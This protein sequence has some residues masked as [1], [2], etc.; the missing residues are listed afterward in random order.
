[1]A[2][3]HFAP[4]VAIEYI[5]SKHK[6]FHTSLARPKPKLVKGD[7]VIVDKRTAF[8]L[9][10]KGFEEFVYVEDIEFKKDSKSA[11]DLKKELIAYKEHNNKLFAQNVALIKELDSLSMTGE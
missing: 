7:I 4:N 5:G 1:M 9:V 8:N 6:E 11:A 3:V 2:K 10:H